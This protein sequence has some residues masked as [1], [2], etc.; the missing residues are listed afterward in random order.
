MFEWKNI[1]C[2][3][4]GAADT[5]AIYSS[6]IDHSEL[7]FSARTF[8]KHTHSQIVKCLSC[9]LIFA[10]P[11]LAPKI[12]RSIYSNANWHIEPQLENM[13]RDYLGELMDVLPLLK[14]RATMLEIGCADGFVLAEA[15]KLFKKAVGVEPSNAAL[16]AKPN[17]NIIRSEF[18]PGLFE[19]NSF[20]FICA[21][22]VLDHLIK[23]METLQEICKVLKPGGIFLA[24]N[25]N[26][27]SPLAR[28]FG[29]SCS[30]Y[31]LQHIYLFDT[32]TIRLLLERGGLEVLKARDIK[33]T[34]MLDYA[35]KMLPLNEGARNNLINLAKLLRISNFKFSIYGGNMV[36]V[37]KKPS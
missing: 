33:S 26:I 16:I 6:K 23:P 30:M 10:N 20:D 22:Q 13:K 18:K 32:K 28:L 27:R 21:F 12:I 11:I 35:I 29:E 5:K 7:I 31:D 19:P 8:P 4:C 25:H 37:G 14:S 2:T 36:A 17:L 34:Y 15:G 1:N 24:V 3:I 9:G